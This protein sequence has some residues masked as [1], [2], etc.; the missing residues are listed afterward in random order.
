VSV[1]TLATGNRVIPRGLRGIDYLGLPLW[2]GDRAVAAEW[3]TEHARDAT[4]HPVM[5]SHINANNY[6]W[7]HRRPD[8]RAALVQHGTLL[9]DGVGLGLG[10]RVLGLGVLPDLNG[11]DLFP[12][13]M[14]RAASHRLRVFLLGGRPQVIERA[15]HVLGERFPG[16]DVAG[17]HHGYF[18]ACEHAELV[19]NIRASRAHLLLVGCGFL[20]QEEF[21]LRFRD[22]LHVPVVWNVGGLFDFVSGAKPRAPRLLRRARLEWL[23]RL[24]IDPRA[25]WHRNLVAAPWF[26]G[27]ALRHC[28][29]RRHLRPAHRVVRGRG[30]LA[31]ESEVRP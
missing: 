3:L 18:E 29:Y 1:T 31:R 12:L 10:A 16:I 24:A 22:A 7:L 21:S 23:F 4:A 25:M 17:Y 15:A 26:L 20:R 13:V 14:R 6:Y 2:T 8:L 11:T 5:V 30:D 27:H 19:R 9:L 28:V